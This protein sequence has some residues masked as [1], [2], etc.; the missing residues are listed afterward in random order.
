MAFGV[1]KTLAALE[2]LYSVYNEADSLAGIDRF[3][4][5]LD[6]EIGRTELRKLTTLGLANIASI[7]PARLALLATGFPVPDSWLL[8][9]PLVSIDA[10][11]DKKRSLCTV[12]VSCSERVALNQVLREMDAQILRL[13]AENIVFDDDLSATTGKGVAPR[14]AWFKRQYQTHGTDTF[15]KPA[16]I[17]ATWHEKA[18]SERAE[19]CPDAPGRVTKAAVDKAIRRLLESNSKAEKPPTRARRRA[20]KAK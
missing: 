2:G 5:P 8:I 11:R 20:G 19:I 15:H 14:N 12:T 10:D 4:F 16:K 13:R 17:A 1:R 7:R 3:S 9:R 6:D 18:V